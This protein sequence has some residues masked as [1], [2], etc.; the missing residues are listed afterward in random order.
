MGLT[1]VNSII[2]SLRRHLKYEKRKTYLLLI[3]IF[4]SLKKEIVINILFIDND[5]NFLFLLKKYFKDLYK[6][7]YFKNNLVNIKDT[8]IENKIDI[9]LLDESLIENIINTFSDINEV[10]RKISIILISSNNM[11][12]LDFGIFKYLE[13]TCINKPFSFLTLKSSIDKFNNN[14]SNLSKN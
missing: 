6:N 11:N 7:K 2:S 8:I 1:Y 5:D 3:F 4:Q 9:I 14:K 12:T 10:R 13:I